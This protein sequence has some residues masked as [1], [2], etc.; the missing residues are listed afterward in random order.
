VIAA[1]AAAT[2]PGAN[3]LL[4]YLQGDVGSTQPVGLMVSGEGERREIGPRCGGEIPPINEL[5]PTDPVWSPDGSRLAVAYRD[6]LATINADGT[7]FRVIDL[8]TVRSPA[9][10]T[11]SPDSR[12]LAFDAFETAG[13]RELYKVPADGSAPPRRVTFRG[14]QSPS[15]SVRGTIAFVREKNIFKLTRAGKVSRVTRRGGYQ[16]SWGP[17]GRAIAF[18]RKNDNS[19]RDAPTFLYRYDV[20]RKRGLRR[21]TRRPATEPSWSPDGHRILFTRA[22]GGNSVILSVAASGGDLQTVETGEEGRRLSVSSGD[23][24]PI[25]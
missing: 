23:L 4:V 25:P 10:P 16:P 14:G 11:W 7:N 9:A 20:A 3:G 8:G 18:I 1:P 2:S 24:Q 21:L 19:L 17:G 15:W 5:C 12:T 22:Q 6:D 13:R